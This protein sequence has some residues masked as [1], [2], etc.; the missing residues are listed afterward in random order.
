M[1]IWNLLFQIGKII[2]IFLKWT[3]NH[4]SFSCPTDFFTITDNT[5]I[6]KGCGWRKY[7][8]DNQLC[9]SVVFVSYIAP[10]NL[11]TTLYK[12]MQIYYECT[13]L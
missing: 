2:N 11:S 13:K 7:A 12:G 4:F 1:L 9:S 6:Y 3:S 10:S 5:G 8:F